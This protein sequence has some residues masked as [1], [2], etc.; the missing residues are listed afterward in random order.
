MNRKYRN[1]NNAAADMRHHTKMAESKVISL[2]NTPVKP[3][4]NTERW[5][6]K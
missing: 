5:S 1:I 4:M 6:R 2:P 3:A